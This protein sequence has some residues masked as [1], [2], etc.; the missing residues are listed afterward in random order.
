MKLLT[1]DDKI[2]E[3]FLEDH[4]NIRRAFENEEIMFYRDIDGKEYR[5]VI[6]LRGISN[7]SA[8]EIHRHLKRKGFTGLKG[9]EMREK[10]KNAL[11]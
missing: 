8:D 4:K 5:K 9:Y 6:D 11:T 7:K 1:L 10:Y 2:N 3:D